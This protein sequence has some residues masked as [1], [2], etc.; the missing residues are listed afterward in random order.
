MFMDVRVFNPFAP[1]N[2]Q[3]SM[4]NCFLKHEKEKRAYEQRV[5]DIELA[6]FVPLVM[7]ATGGMAKEATTFTRDWLPAWLRNGT[8]CTVPP[9]TG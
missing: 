9:Y 1:S 7:T 6:S 8:S 5:R 4:D 3:T 2:S